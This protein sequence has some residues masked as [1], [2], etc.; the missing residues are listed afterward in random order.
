[1]VCVVQV[2]SGVGKMIRT[3]VDDPKQVGG[4]NPGRVDTLQDGLLE[5]GSALGKGFIKGITGVLEKPIKGASK[6]G[7]EGFFKGVGKVR[8]FFCT[9]SRWLRFELRMVLYLMVGL[10]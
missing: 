10:M 4:K 6:E 7:V 5:G 8:I 9:G 3:A 2:L 1:M